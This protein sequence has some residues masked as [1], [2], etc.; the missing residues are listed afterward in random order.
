MDAPNYVQGQYT[1]A[2]RDAIFAKADKYPDAS[3]GLQNQVP[4]IFPDG[5][6]GWRQIPEGGDG[7]ANANIAVVEDTRYASK[8]YYAGDLLIYNGQLYRALVTINSGY[9]LLPDTN[10][11]PTRID[12]QTLSILGKGKNLFRNWYFLG[13]GSQQGGGQFPINQQGLTSYTNAG[14][15]VDG[16]YQTGGTTAV[17]SYGVRHR[18]PAGESSD[19]Y[20]IIDVPMSATSGISGTIVF[21]A[22]IQATFYS[23]SIYA[24]TLT[25]ETVV[26]AGDACQLVLTPITGNKIKATF[27]VYAGYNVLIK[28]AKLELGPISTLAYRVSQ[29]Q[30]TYTL[31]DTPPDGGE[32]LAKC[33]RYLAPIKAGDL[34]HGI[35]LNST[36]YFDITTHQ[37]M[38]SAPVLT[39]VLRLVIVANGGTEE[40]SLPAQTPGAIGGSGI[41]MALAI[42]TIGSLQTAV[43]QVQANTFLS[44]E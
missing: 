6:I 25:E 40:V 17:E 27:R 16:W 41:S 28:A 34:I 19:F 22:L 8:T 11:T 4:T 13:G 39:D 15:T 23:G 24:P 36:F 7:T 14:M 9:I 38:A 31:A 30:T 18:S 32:E 5:S 3:N 21:S 20:Q 12:L 43:A 29:S 35:A 26:F 1:V 37:Q 44:C 2:Q 33:Q 10:I 42:S